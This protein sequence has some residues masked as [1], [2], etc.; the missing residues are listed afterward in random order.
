M[1]FLFRITNYDEPALDAETAEL[2]QQRLEVR[3][4]E[5]VPGLWKVTDRLNACAARGPGWEKRRRR[6]RIYGAFLV[7]LGVFGLVPGLME[8]RIPSLIASGGFAVVMGVWCLCLRERK[9]LRPPASCRKEAEALLAGRRAV[10]W[11]ETAV[12]VCFDE[13]GMTVSDGVHR[14]EVSGED[15]NGVFESKKLWLL[16]Y[17]GENALLLQKK[18]LISGEAEEFLPYIQGKIIENHSSYKGES[19]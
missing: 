18:D 7:V 10:N 2:M 4:R 15:M 9:P 5:A 6:Y 1:E 19:T 12:E 14:E 11:S 16:V 3:S 8:P 13:T 17:D